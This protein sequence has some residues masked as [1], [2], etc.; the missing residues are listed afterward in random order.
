MAYRLKTGT[1][2]KHYINDLSGGGTRWI[3]LTTGAPAIGESNITGGDESTETVFNGV[4]NE[5]AD[6]LKNGSHPPSSPT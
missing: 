4:V 5:I 1:G 6:Y 3:K 2:T